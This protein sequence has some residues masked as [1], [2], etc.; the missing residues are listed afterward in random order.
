M[1]RDVWKKFEKAALSHSSV[2]HLLAIRTL[3]NEQGYVRGTDIAN[4]LQLT[5]GSV[6]ITIKKLKDK[7]YVTEDHNKFL[8]LSEK[9][10]DLVN[11][12]L[13]KRRLFEKL[14]STVL[15]VDPTTAEEDACK[16]EHLLSLETSTKLLSFIGF[17]LSNS[18]RAEKFR[19][20]YETYKYQCNNYD[21][22]CSICEIDCF[23]AQNQNTMTK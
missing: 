3:T 1:I 19:K 23:F 10:M 16:I 6:S 11:A 15:M 22:A 13:S 17:Y 2:H 18:P 5:R 4:Y 20:E 14:F 9:G 12:V 8:R 21:S 7:G